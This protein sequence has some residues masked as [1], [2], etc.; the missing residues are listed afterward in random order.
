MK[1]IKLHII[2]TTKVSLILGILL[3][4]AFQIN[5][6]T[7]KPLFTVSMQDIAINIDKNILLIFNL[8]LKRMIS[9][10]MWV[11]TMLDS[12]IEHYK[13]RDLNSWIYLRFDTITSM[14][15][16]FFWAYYIGAQYLSVIKDDVIGAK[17]LY[18]KG[19][20]RF[21]DNFWLNYHAAFN[22]YWE[23]RDCKRAYELYSKIQYH[24]IALK[25]AIYLP[26]LT[27]RMK[28]CQ[29][30]RKTT[31]KLIHTAWLQAPPKTRLKKRLHE[32]LYSIRA[33][34]DLNCLNNQKQ[35]GCHTTDLNNNPYILDKNG[36][37]TAMQKWNPFKIKFREK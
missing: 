22:Y 25:K 34:E 16:D 32:Y 10:M 4:G 3:W 15:P 19:L 27:A 7:P 5:I 11:Q 33:E 21:P 29:G 18:E 28:F 1:L 6:R 20:K 24:P 26:A 12:D 8:G 13:K 35:T 31:F 30:N 2:Y 9:S 23:L 17:H 37:W 36:K 14:D